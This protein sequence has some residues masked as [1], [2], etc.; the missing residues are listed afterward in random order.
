[1]LASQ[2]IPASEDRVSL[3][4]RRRL[5][6][7]T[8]QKLVGDLKKYVRVGYIHQGRQSHRHSHCSEV[9][10]WQDVL[11]CCAA[12]KRHRTTPRVDDRKLFAESGSRDDDVHVLFVVSMRTRPEMV[13]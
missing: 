5:N 12:P 13:T 8:N 10:L 6:L 1:M 2:G 4:L 11:R 9:G 7:V 3:S